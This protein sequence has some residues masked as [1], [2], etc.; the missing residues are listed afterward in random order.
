MTVLATSRERLEVDGE[1]VLP[2]GPMSTDA[3]TAGE[4]SDA[5]QLFCQRAADVLGQFEPDGDQLVLV[6][7]ICRRLDGLPLAI[8]LAASRLASMTLDHLAEL[9]DERLTVLTRRRGAHARQLS[10]KATV[11]WSYELLDDADQHLFDDVSVFF[12]GFDAVAAEV[13]VGDLS[14]GDRL[15]GLAR[16]C[17]LEPRTGPLGR[18]YEVLE[19]LRQFGD[20]SL[21]ATE[22]L[23]PCRQRHLDYFMT[24]ATAANRGIRSPDEL[25]WHQAILAEWANLKH[26]FG[27]A[28]ERDDADA[29]FHL[30]S[31]L[32]WWAL[33]R[34][35][36]DLA[37]WATAALGLPSGRDHHLRS[38]VGAAA[39][40][41]TAQQGDATLGLAFYEQALVDE[42]ALGPAPEPWLACI[43]PW[44]TQ[45]LT[46]IVEAARKVQRWA[47]RAGDRFWLLVGASQEAAVHGFRLAREEFA[48]AEV[49]AALSQIREVAALADDLGNPNGVAYAS[50]TLGAALRRTDPEEALSLLERSLAL[51]LPLGVELTATQARQ[52]LTQVYTDVGRPLDA[53]AVARDGRASP[54][55]RNRPASLGGVRRRD[56][57]ARG[58]GRIIDRDRRALTGPPRHRGHLRRGDR[59]RRGR[60]HPRARLGDRAVDE[61]LAEATYVTV[62]EAGNGVLDAID[63]VLPRRRRSGSVGEVVAV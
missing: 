22:R 8:E 61:A 21:R 55:C 51:S 12:G 5:V 2:L 20:A 50:R 16:K 32:F 58:G 56:E 26:A 47:Q 33:S 3:G 10:L 30:V 46:V 62:H 6:D 23:V 25:Q 9:L 34:L 60:G 19:T 29:A 31:E 35:R 17:L 38:T 14:T 49:V 52:A 42:E 41:F 7:E 59:C 4:R 45:D 48:P 57:G 44:T 28:C 39:C 24:F 63:R 1:R 43:E 27:T 18:R 37:G 53:L 54:P 13:V 15:D 36:L 40:Y 11:A